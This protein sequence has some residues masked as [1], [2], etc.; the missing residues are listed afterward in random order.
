MFDQTTF[1]LGDIHRE[2]LR[3]WFRKTQLMRQIQPGNPTFSERM[4][5][6]T[7]DLFIYLGLKL[8]ERAYPVY[9]PASTTSIFIAP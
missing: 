2:F 4:L 8:K 1:D 3:N 6:S 7:G 9:K 5:A